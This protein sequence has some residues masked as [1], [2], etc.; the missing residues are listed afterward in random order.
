M[1]T[2]S[3]DRA[4]ILRYLRR[5]LDSATSIVEVADDNVEQLRHVYSLPVLM[6]G[7]IVWE[8]AGGGA[9]RETIVHCTPSP[10]GTTYME[11]LRKTRVGNWRYLAIGL[12]AIGDGESVI[13]RDHEGSSFAI[14]IRPG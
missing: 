7:D 10:S 14:T 5:H 4:T 2:K 12:A 11:I 8:Q 9:P 3:P 6:S 13:L 1:S